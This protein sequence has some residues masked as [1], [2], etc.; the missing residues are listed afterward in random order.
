MMMGAETKLLNWA[1]AKARER[2]ATVLSL[3]VIKGNPVKNLYLHFGLTDVGSDC[4]F[5]S[6]LIGRP[7][8]RFGSDMME[9][10]LV[11]LLLLIANTKNLMLRNNL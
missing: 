7:H 10:R 6:C 11:L 2:N 5:F 8:G 4:F 9:K 1:E 3:A